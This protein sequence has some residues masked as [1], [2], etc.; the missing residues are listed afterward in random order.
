[1]DLIISPIDHTCEALSKRFLINLRTLK[2]QTRCIA[3]ELKIC[4]IIGAAIAAL[5]ETLIYLTKKASNEIPSKLLISIF[6]S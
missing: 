3:A 2:I 6:R 4:G 1:V 5:K